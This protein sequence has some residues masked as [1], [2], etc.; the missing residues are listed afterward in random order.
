MSASSRDEIET[1]TVGRDGVELSGYAVLDRR[2]A[3]RPDGATVRILNPPQTRR[4]G[5][6]GDLLEARESTWELA[7]DGPS[8]RLRSTAPDAQA[9]LLRVEGEAARVLAA[10]SPEPQLTV[11]AFVPFGG[12]DDLGDYY[13]SGR[14]LTGIGHKRRVDSTALSLYRI[15]RRRGGPLWSGVAD[16]LANAIA[17]RVEAA[18]ADGIPHDLLDRGE[19]HVRYLNDT[20]LLMVA[21]A[22]WR[23]G[24]RWHAA[25]ER[26]VELLAGFTVPF[27]GGGWVLHDSL[28]RDA[29]RNDLVLNT[30]LQAIIALRAAGAETAAHERAL[31]A[32]LE[33]RAAGRA[34]LRAVVGIAALE[35]TRAYGSERLTGSRPGR[36]YARA[37]GVCAGQSA[38]RLP[39]G[40]I[41]RDLSG[42]RA[43]AYYAT[44]NLLDLGGVVA[45]LPDPGGRLRAARDRGIRFALRTGFFRAEVRRRRPAA[46]LIPGALR[47]ADRPREAAA[48]AARQR[49]A[50]GAPL[51]GW[52]GYTDSIWGRLEAGTP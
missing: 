50:G 38:L 46:A 35:L 5:E 33:P 2:T 4:W 22:E 29:G 34:A 44:V 48:F 7:A 49:R 37:A 41:G 13:L 1:V 10:D 40:W 14:V 3:R 24:R 12:I 32:A 28:E 16:L 39:G 52:P 20:L 15:A 27:C 23:G 43:P 18:G 51:T 21:Q 17:E 30:H 26:T 6:H 8:A 31:L 42:D 11:P 47:L 36:R 45:N 25:A 19:T 9:E